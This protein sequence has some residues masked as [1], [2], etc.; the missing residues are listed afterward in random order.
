MQ[1]LAMFVLG[2]WRGRKGLQRSMTRAAGELRVIRIVLG[3]EP[4]P[5]KASM[6]CRNHHAK[7]TGLWYH[8]TRTFSYRGHLSPVL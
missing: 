2:V 6:S 3:N 5:Q 4:A 7:R 1:D 8:L